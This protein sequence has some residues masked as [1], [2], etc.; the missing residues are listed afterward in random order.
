MQYVIKCTAMYK[1]KANVNVSMYVCIV[2]DLF[3]GLR[4][5]N[6]MR[7]LSVFDLIFVFLYF[8]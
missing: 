4:N 5:V 1:N 8:V 2:S 6:L 7:K 3:T